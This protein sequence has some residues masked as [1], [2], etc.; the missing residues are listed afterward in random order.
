M[1]TCT[2]CRHYHPDQTS[3]GQG[4]GACGVLEAYKAKITITDMGKLIE[5]ARSKLGCNV[6]IPNTMVFWPL[7]ERNCEKFELPS[8]PR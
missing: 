1:P 6:N 4:I 3:S 8:N 5:A 2:H 7:V